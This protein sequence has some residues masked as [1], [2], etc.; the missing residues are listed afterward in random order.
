MAFWL[1]VVYGVLVPWSGIKPT[2]PTMQGGFLIARPPRKSH[3][4]PFWTNHLWLGLRGR[5]GP[6]SQKENVQ[7]VQNWY[8][9]GSTFNSWPFLK[10]F[11]QIFQ[12]LC[13]YISLLFLTLTIPL[14]VGLGKK[15]FTLF[16]NNHCGLTNSLTGSDVRNVV[17]SPGT[18][19]LVG[20][21]D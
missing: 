16:L 21:T 19:K 18:Y 11:L 15:H 17:F 6:D 10:W 12:V 3:G 20:K 9:S 4:N 5:W 7:R 14:P 8:I 2:L 1:P 13:C